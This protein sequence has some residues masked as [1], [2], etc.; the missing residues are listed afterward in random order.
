MGKRCTAGQLE[1]YFNVRSRLNYQ[2]WVISVAH[3]EHDG[4]VGLSKA[5]VFTALEKMIR[6][7]IA[8]A[9][10]LPP[11][12][13]PPFWIRMSRVDLN[14]T[15]TFLEKNGSTDLTAA[16]EEIFETPIEFADDL[17]LWRVWVFQDGY[18]AFGYDHTLGDG[19][20]GPAFQANFLPT[21]RSIRVIPT[22]HSGVVTG[23]PSDAKMTPAVE[24]AIDASIRMG[25]AVKA[26]SKILFPSLHRRLSTAWTAHPVTNDGIVFENRTRVLFL[27]PGDGKRLVDISREHRT[28]LTGTLHTLALVASAASIHRL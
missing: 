9:A 18:L 6:S 19:Q 26:I 8:L 12:P 27:T 5:L 28:T 25:H 11:A 22:E 10:Q 17:P 14:K 16:L 20:S 2:S 1:R 23:L 3:Y 15:V 4:G 21:L 7:Q 13:A 24:D